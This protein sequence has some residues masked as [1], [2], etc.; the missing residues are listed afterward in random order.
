ARRWTPCRT[1]DPPTHRPPVDPSR[2]LS[3]LELTRQPTG[4]LH[5][6]TSLRPYC[7]AG[8]RRSRPG[9]T[10]C[11]PSRSQP[12]GGRAPP[13]K[14]WW[15]APVI[16]V[17]LLAL[18]CGGPLAA[19]ARL[20]RARHASECARVPHAVRS[21]RGRDEPSPGAITAS[22]PDEVRRVALAARLDDEDLADR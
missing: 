2:R 21:A 6:S 19:S 13:M 17:A 4:A 14:A 1:T 9:S 8:V 15:R 10:P 5:A 11:P 7:Q 20:E 3:A 22:L 16:G 12:A 18:A